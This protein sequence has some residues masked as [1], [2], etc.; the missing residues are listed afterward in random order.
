MFWLSLIQKHPSTKAHRLHCDHTA[1]K[2]WDKTSDQAAQGMFQHVAIVATRFPGHVTC[3]PPCTVRVPPPC[4]AWDR[5]RAPSPQQPLCWLQ[6]GCK[7]QL[8]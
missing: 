1:A 4:A 6:Q 7:Y 3:C 8:F 2:V 5:S